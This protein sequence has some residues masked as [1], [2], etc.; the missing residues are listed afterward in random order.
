MWH[1]DQ[2]KQ[3]T[4]TQKKT[5]D[6]GEEDEEDEE[7]EQEKKKKKKGKDSDN[8]VISSFALGLARIAQDFRQ[9]VR[10]RKHI[11]DQ[12]DAA[13]AQLKNR[14]AQLHNV[15]KGWDI[16]DKVLSPLLDKIQDLYL[17]S[18][19]D[20]IAPATRVALGKITK[21]ANELNEYL[22]KFLGPEQGYPPRQP[23]RDRE[24][25]VG[26]SAMLYGKKML[27]SDV[28]GMRMRKILPQ[29]RKSLMKDVNKSLNTNVPT[30]IRIHVKTLGIDLQ[31]PR[32]DAK[33]RHNVLLGPKLPTTM[34]THA[35]TSKLSSQK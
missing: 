23:I 32:Q 28:H 4:Q 25:E 21:M 26:E 9:H 3:R 29:P 14:T 7:G 2:I 34:K 13:Q 33:T 16:A 17:E 5:D 22:D 27:N 31:K 15:K 35:R 1:D 6:D 30:T 10:E 19:L 8:G 12:R 20:G 24:A 11:L 18:D